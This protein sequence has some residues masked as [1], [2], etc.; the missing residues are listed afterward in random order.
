MTKSDFGEK[1]P[2]FK[3]I[4]KNYKKDFPIFKSQPQLVYLDSAASSLKPE[5]VVKKTTEYYQNYSANI[6]RGIY[7]I[8]EKATQ[9]YE[10]TRDKVADFLNAD[11]RE[12]VFT[13]STTEGL[14]LLAYSLSL[15]VL[16]A[17][18][19]VVTTMMEHH[20]NFVPWQ[21]LCQ[22]FGLEFRVVD[23]DQQGF[24]SLTSIKKLVTSKT[25]VLTF[26]YVS[27]V[28]GTINPVKKIVRMVK[29]I[30]PKTLVVV[31]AAQAAPHLKID[32]NDLGNDFLAFSAHKMLGPTGVGVLWG[33][34]ELLD[35]LQPF[36]Y[37][38]EMIREVHLSQSVFEETPYKFEAGTPDIAGVIAFGQAID[39][40]QRIGLEKIR[41]HELKLTA[42]ALK[43][44]RE[45][46]GE[47]LKILGPQNPKDRGGV[48]AFTFKNYHSHDVAQILADQDVCIRAGHHCAM[49]LHQR[50]GLASSARVSFYLY[51]DEKD[52]EK[53]ITGLKKIER[54]LG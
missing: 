24:L 13:R 25:K 52:V 1:K 16:K 36:N 8:S 10:R 47:S 15:G 31:D 19:E 37:G 51:N 34:K 7:K 44:L 11:S 23:I 2:D 45:E 42:Y 22:R 35:R 26:T 48:L 50:L 5:A 27:N 6:F 41:R 4:M 53:L 17:G 38:G 39:Y 32:V 21:Q 9:E 14:N 18:N 49:P 3:T 30:N 29:K 40:L 54:I 20:A 12:V 46:F 28:L 43:R 33:K